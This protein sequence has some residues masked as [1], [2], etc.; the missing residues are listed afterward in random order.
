MMDFIAK[1]TFKCQKNKRFCHPLLDKEQHRMCFASSILVVP[2]RILNK[3]QNHL[4]INQIVDR[5]KYSF[6]VLVKY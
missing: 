6:R 3:N 4:I 5:I 2:L 1:H